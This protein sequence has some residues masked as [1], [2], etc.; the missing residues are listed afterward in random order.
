VTMILTCFASF[1]IESKQK[2][3]RIGEG[4]TKTF[5]APKE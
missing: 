1:E 5:V 4:F 2:S 3:P